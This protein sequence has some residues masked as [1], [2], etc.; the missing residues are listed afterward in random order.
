MCDRLIAG[1]QNTMW[2]RLQTCFIAQLCYILFSDVLYKNGNGNG[3][4]FSDVYFLLVIDLNK[5]RSGPCL[6]RGHFGRGHNPGHTGARDLP[7]YYL[8]Y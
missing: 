4:G 7:L 2:P 3:K 1:P 6:V 5:R 8:K